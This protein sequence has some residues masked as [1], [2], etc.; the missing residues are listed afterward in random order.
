MK[1]DDRAQ[2][3]FFSST[4]REIVLCFLTW[5]FESGSICVWS[6]GTCLG[7]IWGHWAQRSSSSLN[8]NLRTPWSKSDQPRYVK[9]PNFIHS[10]LDRCDAKIWVSQGSN[11]GN[12]YQTWTTWRTCQCC[13]KLICEINLCGV[14]SLYA[15]R[16]NKQLSCKLRV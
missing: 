12:I 15:L 5:V 3:L 10:D 4:D 13:F 1:E 14:R 9:F 11:Y 16:S 2:T 7:K 6:A 8:T